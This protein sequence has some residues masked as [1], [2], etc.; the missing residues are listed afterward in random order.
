VF[1][2]KPYSGQKYILMRYHINGRIYEFPS[3]Y[4]V[5]V[6]DYGR[7]YINNGE[8]TT[9]EIVSNI[10][11]KSPKCA[12]RCGRQVGYANIQGDANSG[13]KGNSDFYYINPVRPNASHDLRVFANVRGETRNELPILPKNSIYN[14]DFYYEDYY[15][16]KERMGD[17]THIRSIHD[18]RAAIEST[19]FPLNDEMRKKYFSTQ[20]EM[21]FNRTVPWVKAAVMDIYAD[22]RDYEFTV[23]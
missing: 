23:L 19:S 3:E 22:G 17:S 13:I 9:N 12:P 4:I 8:T 20:S 1:V 15:G 6:I 5:K 18:L 7:N 14:I 16:T 11:C 21:V 2:Y 10:I